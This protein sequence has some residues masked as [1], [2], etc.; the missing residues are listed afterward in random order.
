M[1]EMRLEV[2]A[3]AAALMSGV[4]FSLSANLFSET[5]TQQVKERNLDC[6]CILQV[7]LMDWVIFVCHQNLKLIK[8]EWTICHSSILWT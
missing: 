2:F 4:S 6:H 7:L 1:T 5:S 3:E 8:F